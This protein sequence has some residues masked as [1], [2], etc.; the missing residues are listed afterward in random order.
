ML[1]PIQY[2]WLL[3]VASL[4]YLVRDVL[5]KRRQQVVRA[6]EQRLAFYDA[7]WRSAAAEVGA[8]VATPCHGVLELTLDDAQVKVRANYTCLDDP[9][10][11]FVAGNKPWVHQRL[12]ENGLPTPEYLVFDTSQMREAVAFLESREAP[13]V[14]KPAAGTGAGQGVTAGIRTR[15]QLAA[16]VVKAIRYHHQ[17]VLEQQVPGHNYRLLYLDGVLL[18]AVHRCPPTVI[19]DGRQTIRSLVR[20]ENVRRQAGW[21]VAQVLLQIDA[22]M[23]QTLAKQGL[24]LRSVPAVDQP[25]VLKT[26]INENAA[27]ENQSASDQLCAEVIAAGAEAAKVLQV[28]LAGVDVITSNPTVALEEADGVI[29]EVNTTPGLYHHKQGAD[30]PVSVPILETMLRERQCHPHDAGCYGD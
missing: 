27:R 30:C 21:Q 28:R 22:D 18:D 25:V 7:I 8:D 1:H 3:R 2:S 5:R 4:A 13:C 16:A 24:T 29:L 10:T 20:E 26:V 14:V 23:R 9:V 17:V 15:W 12:A 11:L 6:A 19:G